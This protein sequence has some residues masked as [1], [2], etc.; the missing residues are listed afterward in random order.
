MTTGGPHEIDITR[1]SSARMYDWYLG[2]N[3]NYPVDRTF[4]ERMMQVCPLALVAARQNRAA[5]GRIVRHLAEERGIRQ[6]IDIGSGV[7]TVQNVHQVA[8]AV[9]PSIR[10]VY[11]DKDDEAIIA[12]RQMLEHE[13]NATAVYGDIRDVS[14]IMDNE[15]TMRYIDF[16]EPVGLLMMAVLHFVSDEHNPRELVRRYLDVFPP[17]SYFAATHVT[18]D[19]LSPAAREQFLGAEREY[20][21]AN[22][23]VTLRDREQFTAFF[24]GLEIIEPGVTYAAD[25]MRR[26]GDFDGVD[27]P[28]QW[29]EGRPSLWAA[30]ARKP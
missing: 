11:S 13:P 7:P 14:T 18:V 15:Q 29:A 17:G 6:F 4:G 24:D 22:D 25:W 5:L 21:K 27:D 10:V 19:E 2:G 12:S 16:A 3:H 28:E 9:D 1:P 30:V 26:P 23:P 8:H 20:G